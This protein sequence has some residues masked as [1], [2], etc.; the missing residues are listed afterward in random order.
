MSAEHP[1]DLRK[2]F[3]NPVF[4][5]EHEKNLDP[6]DVTA[7]SWLGSKLIVSRDALVEAIKQ[8]E[9]LV[10]WLEPQLQKIRWNH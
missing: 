5:H 1:E 10:D 6:D 7:L 2:R 4:V 8:V 3:P 9:L